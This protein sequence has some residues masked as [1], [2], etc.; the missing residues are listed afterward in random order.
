MW[1]MHPIADLTIQEAAKL[2]VLLFDLDD[3]FLDGTRLGE[4]AFRSLALLRES[5]LALV[6][7]TGRPS[8]WGEVIARQWPI[9]AAVT[10][11]GAKCTTRP[12]ASV[13][14]DGR[15]WAV[16][17]RACGRSSPTFAR[18]TT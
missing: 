6:A 14:R 1:A 18:P 7:V 15:P 13:P 8:G 10:E 16:W 2:R 11:N 3:T 4:A 12:L 5:G 17:W 9:D